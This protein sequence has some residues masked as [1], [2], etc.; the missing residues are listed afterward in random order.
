MNNRD[1]KRRL[2]DRLRR[3]AGASKGGANL[4]QLSRTWDTLG[5]RDALWAILTQPGT[6]G[7]GWDVE[8]FFDSGREQVDGALRLV[9]DEIGWPIPSGRALDFGCGVGRLTQALCE[10]FEQVDGVDIAAS[11]I[12]GAERFNRFGD[13]CRYHLNRR[14][15]LSIFADRS[16]DFIYSTYVFQHMRPSFARGYVRE[17]VRVLTA[18]GVALFQV[19]TAERRNDPMHG[20]WFAA[21]MLAEEPL[22]ERL[23]PDETARVSIR[24]TN[25]GPG[26]WPSGGTRAVRAG[27]RWHR[28]GAA[29]GG[30]TRGVLP[31]DLGPNESAV[32]TL[33]LLGPRRPGEYE[34][35]C[36]LLQED[37]AWFVDRGGSSIRG[38][39]SVSGQTDR[40]A[41]AEGPGDV[42]GM[43]M[44]TIPIEDVTGWVDGAGGR[45]L[46]V[47]DSPPD[48]N[49]EGALIAAVLDRS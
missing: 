14:D 39:V 11:M 5:E 18:D 24:V 36:G 4:E 40:A 29:V 46:R 20:T 13:R 6:R 45:V 12:R 8:R 32:V 37:V 23:S 48:P 15:D 42:P 35:E 47:I 2:R 9:A 27:A 26:T 44:H 10:R 28:D 21:D 31:G 3:V 25:R 34:V 33:E 19:A 41:S 22:P 1:V 17:F 43:E 49:Y 30:E 16:F 7:G 38:H